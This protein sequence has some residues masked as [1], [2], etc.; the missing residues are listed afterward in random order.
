M[1]RPWRLP[2]LATGKRR[3]AA[4]LALVLMLAA[5]T[6]RPHYDGDI[7]EYAAMAAA[8]ANHGTPDIRPGDIARARE[9]APHPGFA[10]HFD[11]L[12]RGMREA[13]GSPKPGFE[14]ARGG[15]GVYSIHFFTYSALGAIA[16]SVLGALGLPLGHSFLVVNLASVFVLGMALHRLLGTPAR[17]TAGILLFFAC[18]GILYWNWCSPE[19]ASAA[20]LLSALAYFAT[21]APIAG[22]LLAGLAATQSPPIV[23]LAG[24]GPLFCWLLNYRAGAG[25]RTALKALNT[26]RM[27]A[28]VALC[29]GLAFMPPL[30]SLA[31][32]GEPSLIAKHSTIPALI[33]WP[34]LHSFLF[35]PNQGLVVGI[36]ALAIALAACGWRGA[37][38]QSR[39]R[40]MLLLG[41]ALACTLAL[42]LPALSALNWNSAA[43][44]LMRYGSWA[45]MP[46]LF[47]FLLYLRS[48]EHWPREVVALVLALQALAMIHAHRYS[49][50]EF[51][52][53]AR[54][55]LTHAPGLYNPD[56]EIFFERLTHGEPP[57]DPARA[58]SYAVDGR[59]YKTLFSAD[60][61]AALQ[62]CGPGSAITNPSVHAGYGHWR[63]FDGA[64]L[65]TSAQ[66][67]DAERLAHRKLLGAGWNALEL[68][69][70]EWNGVWSSG[71]RSR[72][73]L[74]PGGAQRT[75]FL[76]LT[77]HYY[78][79]NART[80]LTVNGHDFGWHALDRGESID[81]G[82]AVEH[83]GV[84]VD[85]EL[86]H[87]RPGGS[88]PQTG[89]QRRIAFF[90]QRAEMH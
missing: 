48:A 58:H 30:I 53:A 31:L 89:D 56:P 11:D 18:G 3:F 1:T 26:P 88:S 59:I 36:P 50:L 33:G 10:P 40:H 71:A 28:G 45:A 54:W 46:L 63:Y 43:H 81:I 83:T 87:Q 69:G 42:A 75:R 79:G 51:S 20:A 78:S 72:I 52:P 8:M 16:L 15:R 86:E 77:G 74:P 61:G 14:R 7:V 73:T 67:L 38:P 64:P 24:F 55:M 41:A 2:E 39:R 13:P 5:L 22:G 9:V 12:E 25:A 4:V 82:A 49:Y 34:R 85:I 68:G 17:A 84:P 66:V 76:T 23:F 44:G 57:I 29:A 80:R 65:C 35:D 21:G 47:A 19:L 70:G 90:L 62:L 60:G 32:F 37:G 27:Y 6:G